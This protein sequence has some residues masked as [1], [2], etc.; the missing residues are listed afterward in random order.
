MRDVI[1][2]AVAGEKE[3][4]HRRIARV[5][6]CGNVELKEVEERQRGEEEGDAPERRWLEEGEEERD[7]G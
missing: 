3:C 1:R 6:R 4:G 7:T 2:P 5:M